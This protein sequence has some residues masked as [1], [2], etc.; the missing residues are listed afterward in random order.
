MKSIYTFIGA[1]LSMLSISCSAV[2]NQTQ[3]ITVD[4]LLQREY[5]DS[6]I[7][8]DE[9]G[10]VYFEKIQARGNSTANFPYSYPLS[11]NNA[12]KKIFVAPLNGKKEAAQLFSQEEDTGYYFAG[13]NPWSPN[14]RYLTIYKFKNGKAQPGVFDLRQSRVRFFDVIARFE[15]ITSFL[16][17]TSDNEFMLFRDEER[18][19][20]WFDIFV[21]S[22]RMLAEAREKGWSNGLI[23]SEIVGDGRY[24]RRSLPKSYDLVR[25]NV[26]TGTADKVLEGSDAAIFTPKTFSGKAII[27][28]KT[29]IDS[30]RAPVDVFTKRILSLMDLS[31]SKKKHLMRLVLMMQT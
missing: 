5:I 12:L 28:E 7:I 11:V 26:R 9:R 19:S 1:A 21:G 4:S 23:T 18:L 17:W 14:G 20:V 6:V 15:P 22:S 8:D 13:P 16:T 27:S 30:E 31:L 25:V 2:A 10:V 24:Y 29:L 3:T